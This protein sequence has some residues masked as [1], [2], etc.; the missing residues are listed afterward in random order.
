LKKKKK[1]LHMGSQ[2]LV[3]QAHN[4]P[5]SARKDAWHEKTIAIML[6]SPD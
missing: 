5:D 4:A 2:L 6:H 1:R 3:I